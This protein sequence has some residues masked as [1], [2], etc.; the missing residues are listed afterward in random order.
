MPTRDALHK[1]Y[2]AACLTLHQICAT[3]GL[4]EKETKSKILD[5]DK[6]PI[7]HYHLLTDLYLI[8]LCAQYPRLLKRSFDHPYRLELEGM[9][10]ESYVR[11]NDAQDPNWEL[12][13]THEAQAMPDSESETISEFRTSNLIPTLINWTVNLATNNN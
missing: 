10:S 7:G 13:D 8:S 5:F 6:L 3:L 1:I 9:F 11:T 2:H 12:L 4:L